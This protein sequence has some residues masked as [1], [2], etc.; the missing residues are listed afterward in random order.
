MKKSIAFL[1]CVAAMALVAGFGFAGSAIVMRV[2]VPFEFYVEDQLLPA[3][4][5]R[6]E[7]GAFGLGPTASSVVIRKED[8][9]GVRFVTT[10]GDSGAGAHTSYLE[11][12]RYGEQN[13]LSSVAVAGFTAS[14]RSAKLEREL[15]AAVLREARV[16]LVAKN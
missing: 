8:G 12:R 11:F 5:Y 3:G 4:E 2:H 15:R 14:V 16:T 13:F 9:T 10:R 6:F 7:M 1:G